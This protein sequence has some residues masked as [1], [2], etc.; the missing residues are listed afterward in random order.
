[1]SSHPTSDRI[2][3]DVHATWSPAFG[4]DGHCVA[5]VSD[6]GGEPQVWLPGSAG[7]AWQLLP[8]PLHR[9]VTVAA[10]PHEPW[11]AV[12]TESEGSSCHQI[13]VVQP[14]GGGLRLV[15][16]DAV[17]TADLGA[18]P[19]RGWSADGR[20]MVTETRELS[21][22]MLIEPDSGRREVVSSGPLQWFADLSDDGSLALLRRGGR[23]ARRLVVLERTTG[24]EVPVDTGHGPGSG[25][26]SV[27]N[28]VL[29]G[30][31]HQV[32]V[33]TDV[34]RDLAALVAV[35]PGEPPHVLAERPDAELQSATVAPGRRDVCLLWN[36]RGGLSAL[37]VLDL[38]TRQLRTIEPLP[39][40][41]VDECRLDRT[42]RRLLL[43]AESW[44]APRG[45]WSCDLDGGSFRYVSNRE[46]PVV[47]AS[48][49]AGPALVRVRDLTEPEL[50]EFTAT[51]GTA[52]T[53]WLYPLAGPPPWPTLIYLHGGPEA[54]ERPVYNSLFQSLAAAG[55]AVCAPNVRGS[56]GFGRGFRNADNGAQRW[57]A[58]DDVAVCVRHLVA[59]GQ[60]DPGAVG[61]MGRSYGGYLT[62]A[63]LVWHPELFAVGVDVCGMADFHTFFRDSE[64]WIA[65]AAITKYGDPI[66]DADLLRDLSPIHLIDRVRA[67]LMVVHGAHDTNVP[68]GE[69]EQVVAALQHFGVPH[70]YLLFPG[71]G[72]EL[73]GTANRVV[74]VRR[75]VDWVS[76]HLS[77]HG[78]VESSPPGHGSLEHDPTAQPAASRPLIAASERGPAELRM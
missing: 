78:E 71:E 59:T 52:L 25:S 60:A 47:H 24:A 45:V 39:R 41:V 48:P 29:T 34:G 5:C 63:A 75:V 68:L 28:G 57:A 10:A 49:G 51:D 38:T 54:Q 26:G 72:H 23:D 7:H 58:I 42:G 15:A 66:A 50:I 61:V 2:P 8:A 44:S 27:E 30:H 32:V 12:V 31:G 16:G 65:Q 11:L 55:I 70:D 43:T 1:V 36:V 37:S 69:A 67:P 40:P 64:P 6:R 62:L 77:M 46:T 9:V 17:T 76:R 74:F 21:T 18:G 56:S 35:T 20:V 4:P 22:A 3:G 14:D 13:W 53:G 33:R 73:F 19:W